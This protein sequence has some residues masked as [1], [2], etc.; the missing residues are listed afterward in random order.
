MPRSDG[1]AA[2]LVHAYHGFRIEPLTNSVVFGFDLLTDIAKG[3]RRAIV[4]LEADFVSTLEQEGEWAGRGIRDEVALAHLCVF[5][6]GEALDARG[7]AE[8]DSG[9]PPRVVCTVTHPRDLALRP[10]ADAAGIVRYAAAKMYWESR[11]NGALSE[12]TLPDFW[13]LGVERDAVERAMLPGNEEYWN[14]PAKGEHSLRYVPTPRL[15]RDF[16]TGRLAGLYEP[17]EVSTAPHDA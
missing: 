4:A 17:A 6:I 11:F 15:L 9:H 16:P 10:R 7:I 8:I 5:A 3:T 13:R 12:F 14:G 2:A 1:S